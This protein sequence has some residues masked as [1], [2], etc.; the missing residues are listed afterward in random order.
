MAQI[1]WRFMQPLDQSNQIAAMASGNQQINAGLAAMGNAVTGYADA[2][3]QRNTDEILNALYQAQTSADLPNAMSAVSALQQQYGRGFDQAAVRN[4]IDTRGSTLAQRDLQQINLQQAQ[5]AQAAIPQLNALAAQRMQAAGATP[6]QLSA[7]NAVQGI[8]MTQQAQ[9]AIG[10]LRDTRDFNFRSE[11]DA[12]DFAYRVQ[13]DAVGDQQW[14]AANDRADVS[15]AMQMAGMYEQAPQQ[16][17]TTDAQGNPV[18][19][20]SSGVTKGDAFSAIMGN[21][22]QTE[23]NG[24]HR[25]KNGNLTRSP[26]GA[27]GIAQ[28]MPATAAKPGYGMQPINLQTSSPQEQVQWAN[29]YINR[30]ANAHGFTTEQAVAAYNAGPGAVQKAIQQGGSKWLSK[31]PKETQNYVPKVMGGS[32]GSAASQ[33]TRAIGGVSQ[34]NMSKVT[35]DYQQGIAKLNA[36]YAA[37][38][39]KDQIKGSLA[40]T[41]KSVDTWAASNRGKDNTFFTNAGD[42]AKMAKQ[43]P[44][45][46]KLPE[47]AQIN[48][49]NGAFA[50]MNDVNAFQYVPDSQLKKYISQESNAYKQDR[51]NQFNT[52]KQALMEKAYQGIVAQYQAAGQ[53]PPSRDGVR[54]MLDPQAPS[55]APVPQPVNPPQQQAQPAKQTQPKAQ[56][57]PKYIQEREARKQAQR[58]AVDKRLGA[59]KAVTQTGQSSPKMSAGTI[60]IGQT[61]MS[62]K[63]LDDILKKY[64]VS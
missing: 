44:V 42:L 48:V 49:L 9:Q 19:F 60:R 56:Q 6:E 38:D 31:L 29:Q 47:A 25:D 52:Q 27:L 21:L 45:F 34:A 59:T 28:I 14:Q 58:D 18:P 35:S 20:T 62:Q 10:D 43:D 46:N 17:W 50:K 57:T 61:N 64:K 30:I 55:Q 24:N 22:I 54:R 53:K 39:A 23:S 12:R 37:Q 4:A 3:R 13:R 41:G 33:A 15:T 51:I 63:Q 26:A 5:N 11:K 32:S 36:D 7:F 16:G 40:S 2:T 1:D 8:D